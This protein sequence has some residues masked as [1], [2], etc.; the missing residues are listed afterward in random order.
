[1]VLVA[2]GRWRVWSR[3]GDARPPY[4][5]AEPRRSSAW[6]RL[7][8][9]YLCATRAG[10]TTIPTASPA[11]ACRTGCGRDHTCHELANSYSSTNALPGGCWCQAWAACCMGVAQSSGLWAALEPPPHAP[12]PQPRSGKGLHRPRDHPHRS[13]RGRRTTLEVLRPG[14]G[15]LQL[16]L[17]R[18]VP[19]PTGLR[20]LPVL[21]PKD[22]ARGQL[23]AVKNGIALTGDGSSPGSG[24]L[25]FVDHE[26]GD[27]SLQSLA[28]SV[29]Q[30]R[31]D[32]EPGLLQQFG[33]AIRR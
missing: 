22:S 10:M 1:M 17:L 6:Q 13:R 23:L 24:L 12:R 2:G 25:R 5:P 18:Q 16:R 14:R 11:Y 29:R 28:G 7:E 19:P 20:P 8:V 30:Y 31:G 21:L 32:N 3:R 33:N 15:L 9:A 26:A 27:R 4:G